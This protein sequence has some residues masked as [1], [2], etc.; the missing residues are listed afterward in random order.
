[1]KE[2]DVTFILD[3]ILK[4]KDSCTLFELY[5]AARKYME[6]HKDTYIDISGD[7]VDS[8]LYSYPDEYYCNSKTNTV[9]KQE[10]VKCCFCNTKHRKY[11]N[12][13][14]FNAI[15]EANK[16]FKGYTEEDIHKAFSAGMNR[17]V[18]VATVIIGR[19]IEG[20]YPPYGEYITNIKKIT[21]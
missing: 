17:G 18:H 19:P 4:E 11:P 7:T 5:D 3:I 15:V 13:E 8:Y 6:N 2:E 20:D 1:M 12:V 16:G 10:S 14:L 21:P 9:Y